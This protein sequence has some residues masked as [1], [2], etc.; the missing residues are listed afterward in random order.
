MVYC[1]DSLGFYRKIQLSAMEMD[2][3]IEGSWRLFR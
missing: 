3:L 1:T 2:I